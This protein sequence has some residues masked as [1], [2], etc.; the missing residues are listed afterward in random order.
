MAN[1]L[2][3]CIWALFTAIVAIPYA[4]AG[5]HAGLKEAIDKGDYTT[6]ANMAQKMN[7]PGMYLPP[8]LSIKDAK[9][10]YGS[11]K[12]ND[13]KWIL[14][15]APHYDPTCKKD[16]HSECSPQFLDKYVE[17]LCTE[18]TS[19]HA[20]ACYDWM[21]TTTLEDWK[22]VEKSLCQNK[23]T[24]KP[25]SLYVQE[26]PTS[27][28]YQILKELDKKG[29]LRFMKEVEIDTTIEQTIPPKE[30]LKN[31]EHFYKIT[32]MD[33]IGSKERDT[34]HNA[35]IYGNAIMCSFDYTQ[36]AVDKCLAKL[37][38]FTKK[39]KQ[40]CKSGQATKEVN[41]KKKTKRLSEPFDLPIS[42]IWKNLLNIPWF[43]MDEIWKEKVKFVQKYYKNQNLTYTLGTEEGWVQGLTNS[44][45]KSSN[46]EISY[47]KRACI[48]YPS[49]DKT[50]SKKNGITLFSCNKIL[51]DYPNY[52]NEHCEAKDF[53]WTK[54]LPLWLQDQADSV[55]LI[56][57]AKTG[58]Y[59]FEDEFE[60]ITQEP[61]EKVDSSWLKTYIVDG[62][63]VSIVC[64]KK[65]GG[66]R[67]A[68]DVESYA[69]GL[70]ESP[71]KSWIDRTNKIVCDKNIGWRKADKFEQ[72][73][74]LCETPEQSWID[75]SKSVVCDAKT[76]K[77]RESN[78]FE[79]IAGTLCEHPEKS[80]IDKTN[81][82]VCDKNVGWRDADEFERV[83]GLCENPEK[84]WIITNEDGRGKIVCDA[85]IGKYREADEFE[86]LAGELCESPEKDWIKTYENSRRS[87]ETIVCDKKL[88]HFR[89]A[90][91]IEVFEGLCDDSRFGE[92][93]YYIWTCTR[94]GWADSK[95][96]N[97]A[98]IVFTKGRFAK[99]KIND[100]YVY[101]KN[102]QDN[103][104]YRATKINSSIW[105]SE[106]LQV[107]NRDFLNIREALQKC[108]DGWHLPDTTEWSALY[109][110]TGK[111]VSALM[112][113]D[114]PDWPQATDKL[115]FSA[116]PKGFLDREAGKSALASGDVFFWT[117][118]KNEKGEPGEAYVFH[119]NGNIATL[120][121]E[122]L[123]SRRSYNVRCIKNH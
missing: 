100:K 69:Q 73:G 2:R 51:S 87:K 112:A 103:N 113:K 77:F 90:K 74:G 118:A 11:E 40:I 49:I 8:N 105:M 18:K 36:Q 13:Y 76:G 34:K 71:Q 7:V 52:L 10:I 20:Q 106:N 38:D 48:V 1:N 47:V 14:S 9:F 114:L 95:E 28:R 56:C 78:K 101:F 92:E 17:M 96:A 99:G 79:R 30:C 70:C 102:S 29:L 55:N 75:E 57:D 39:A 23:E 42:S 85:K 117:Y 19:F 119:I 16:Q 110:E 80:W 86:Q 54:K 58:K 108:P 46:L 60:S 120:E 24:I 68:T 82:V 12:F 59:R 111:N 81:R 32:K 121:N 15:I 64:D 91:E 62:K 41:K 115:R 33:I 5:V 21:K 97:T 6:A 25:C 122:R 53:S 94:D 116:I 27:I 31:L 44:Y 88:D 4:S 37:D 66:Y 67:I 72:I 109:K 22:K 123:Y 26:Q 93:K 84:S 50:M 35:V 3:Q 98:G 65:I 45:A 63:T 104:I 107:Q 89:R 83:G 43:A 61:C